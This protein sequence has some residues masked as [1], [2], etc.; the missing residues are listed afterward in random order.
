M[1]LK[2]KGHCHLFPSAGFQPREQLVPQLCSSD[3][4]TVN[5]GIGGA[6]R[7]PSSAE[8]VNEFLQMNSYLETLSKL[9]DQ[10]C[11]VWGRELRVLPP[12][13]ALTHPPCSGAAL[14]NVFGTVWSWVQFGNHWRF[15]LSPSIGNYSSH[16]SALTPH[17]CR[18]LLLPRPP[19]QSTSSLTSPW[20]SPSEWVFSSALLPHHFLCPLCS[21]ITFFLFTNVIICLCHQPPI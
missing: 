18:L 19:P 5:F 7:G 2:R 4:L 6:L 16:P 14:R 15:P 8:G 12:V 11:I 10:S 13:L 20:L 3:D 21:Q 1:S 17:V 9:V